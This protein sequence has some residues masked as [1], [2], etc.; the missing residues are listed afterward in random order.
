MI[1]T[2]L[3]VLRNGYERR[4]FI[5]LIFILFAVSFIFKNILLRFEVHY[6]CTFN[7]IKQT[8]KKHT[9]FSTFQYWADNLFDLVSK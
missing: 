9:I 6:K 5:S 4:S 8:K 1:T 3:S 2:H 7:T